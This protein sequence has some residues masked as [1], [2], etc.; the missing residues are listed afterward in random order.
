MEVHHE[1]GLDKQPAKTFAK[2]VIK[3]HGN[4]WRSE[5]VTDAMREALIAQRALS[6]V[7]GQLLETVR[8]EDV[9][10]LLNDMRE[11]AGLRDAP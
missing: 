4:A 8:V 9:Q 3:L 7:T 5:F 10:Q 2:D 6:I 1:G 11:A